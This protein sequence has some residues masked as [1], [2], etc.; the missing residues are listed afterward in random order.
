MADVMAGPS[1]RT[2]R[3]RSES[4]IILLSAAVG[5]VVAAV[6]RT[7]LGQLNADG[8][9][10]CVSVGASPQYCRNTEDYPA[11]LQWA[12]AFLCGWG[13]FFAVW[14]VHTLRSHRWRN[15]W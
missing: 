6:V 2:L 15:A 7:R 1:D 9:R 11:V 13:S 8:L 10:S 3:P 12:Y 5:I 14:I 4:W